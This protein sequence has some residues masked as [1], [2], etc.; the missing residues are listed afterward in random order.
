M[1]PTASRAHWQQLSCIQRRHMLHVFV[2]IILL[3]DLSTTGLFPSVAAVALGDDAVI[4]FVAIFVA[5]ATFA[6]GTAA[7]GDYNQSCLFICFR[8]SLVA[9]KKLTALRCVLSTTK[10][11]ITTECVLLFVGNQCQTRGG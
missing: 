1:K 7:V 10:I 11:Q 9:A 2:R 6:V 3:H 5:S 4:H 8:T